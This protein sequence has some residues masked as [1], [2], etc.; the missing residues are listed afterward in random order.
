MVYRV[1]VEKK[2]KLAYEAKSLKSELVNLLNIKGIEKLRIV[3]RYDAENIDADLFEYCKTT[4]FSEPQLDDVYDELDLSGAK[5]FAVEFLPGQFDQRANSA[6]ECIQ[7]ISMG[8]RPDVKSAKVYIITG[9][10]SD[11]QIRMVIE[12]VGYGVVEICEK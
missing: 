8:E 1:Y 9:D 11:E 4:V 10:V 6:S 5:A 2:E 7:L 3:N 12:K